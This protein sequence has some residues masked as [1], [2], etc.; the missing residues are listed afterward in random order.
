VIAILETG[1]SHGAYVPLLRANDKDVFHEGT[2][3]VS[4]AESYGVRVDA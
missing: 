1:L 4:A 3:P 2:P